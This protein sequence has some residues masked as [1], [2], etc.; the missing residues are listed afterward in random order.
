MVKGTVYAL[1]MYLQCQNYGQFCSTTRQIQDTKL[2]RRKKGNAL[3][4]LGI[5]IN[6][7]NGQKY[8]VYTEHLPPRP[9]FWSVFKI[10]GFQK[11]EMH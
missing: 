9:K 10:Q 3:N 6:T 4:D 5:I 8:S 7:F 1:S 2:L 11:S